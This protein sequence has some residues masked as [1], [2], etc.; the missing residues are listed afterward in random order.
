METRKEFD[1]LL[2][3]FKHALRDIDKRDELLWVLRLL[4][5]Y[6]QLMEAVQRLPWRLRLKYFACTFLIFNYLRLQKQLGREDHPFSE[7]A[8]KTIYRMF[9]KLHRGTVPVCS[10]T[11]N[12]FDNGENKD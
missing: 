3:E 9:Q 12:Y 7:H 11:K 1:E 10:K 6:T 5:S 4:G 8:R 2:G